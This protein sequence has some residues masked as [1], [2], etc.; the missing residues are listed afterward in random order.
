MTAEQQEQAIAGSATIMLPDATSTPWW[1]APSGAGQATPGKCRLLTVYHRAGSGGT[2]TVQARIVGGV[3]Q[4]IFTS[5]SG[6]PSV[7]LAA[8]ATTR[9]RS[10]GV[11]WY[12][13]I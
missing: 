12:R 6:A 3:Q 8:G 13:E 5:N 4:Q 2:C 1:L 7:T 11:N 10:D 9:L